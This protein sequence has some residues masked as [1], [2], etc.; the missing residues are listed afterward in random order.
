MENPEAYER[1][2]KRVE[3]KVGFYIHLAVYV[4]VNLLLLVINLT[5]SPQYLWFKWP[6]LGWGIGVFFH[7]LSVF[8]F[9]GERF[10]GIKERMIEEEMKKDSIIKK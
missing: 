9:S 8:V 3:V 2:K 6:L 5:R 7:G 1:A 4:G 10:K